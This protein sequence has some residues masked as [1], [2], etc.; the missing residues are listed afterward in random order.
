MCEFP[1]YDVNEIVPNL[2]LGNLKSAYS[3]SFLDNYKI[4]N[5]LTLYEDFDYTKKIN[6]INYLIIPIR[7]RD[8]DNIKLNELFDLTNQ[9]IYQ[10][11][12]RKEGILV[13]CKKGHHRSGATVAAFLIK[14]Y[15]FKYEDAIKY[16]NSLRPCALR[17]DKHMSNELFKYIYPNCN[18]FICNNNGN[19]Y[20]CHCKNVI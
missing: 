7:D 18:N 5:I 16:I 19:Y 20:K 2:W 10:A 9:F 17:R 12:K 11:L 3:K 8:L 6:G 4:K 13:H 15:K 1:E 14:C